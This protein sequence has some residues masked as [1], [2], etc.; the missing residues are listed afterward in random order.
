MRI[1]GSQSR[2]IPLIL[3][4]A[5]AGLVYFAMTGTGW[6]PAPAFTA[7]ITVLCALWWMTEA[8]PIPATSL[9]PLALFPLVGILDRAQVA[10]AFGNPI[11]FLLLGGFIL[12]L[13][14]ASSG[15]HTRI[16]MGVLG[17][18]KTH[19]SR[20][21]VYA[22]MASS[23][24]LSLWISNA[25]TTMM[26]LPV[27]L[28]VLDRA[29]QK[30]HLTVP[31]LLGICYAASIGGMGTPIGTPPN[32]IFMEM[33]SQYTE[34]EV[35][36]LQWMKWALP[37]VIGLLPIVAWRITRKLK[38]TE[39]IEVVTQGP[40]KPAERRVLIIFVV[41]ALLWMT[42]KDPFGGWSILL[43]WP[44]AH[45][46]YVAL[47]AAVAVFII[48]GG[49]GRPLLTW[50]ATAKLPWGIVLLVAGGLTLSAAL[51]Q[52]GLTDDLAQHLGA[53]SGMPPMLLVLSI[54]IAVTFLTELTSNSASTALLMPILATAAI[55]AKIDPL[56]LMLPAALSASCAFML[57]M[58]TAPNAIIFGSNL[59]SIRDMM[60]HGIV[61][62]VLCALALSTIF[63]T[64]IW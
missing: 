9:I 21:V 48:P 49:D 28:A 1:E 58:A 43:D 52:T 4:P 47:I 22:F 11:N 26:L 6:A 29:K 18:I 60:R 40:W 14:M 62:N 7:G 24:F 53:L 37:V 5:L 56:L 25:A 36:F 64:V 57:P 20:Y 33:Y 50:E 3:G 17:L 35:T 51:K 63:F 59:V 8:I 42:R 32:L 44:N 12:S 46:G 34:S 38:T 27:A 19:N 15:A 30:E 16:A 54:C 31:L 10:S 41:T 55:A 13:A 39:R 23:A 61:L 2:L 45:D